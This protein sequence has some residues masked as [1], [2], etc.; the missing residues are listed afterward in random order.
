MKTGYIYTDEGLPTL[1][2]EF[3]WKIGQKVR[4]KHNKNWFFYEPFM[5][6]GCNMAIGTIVSIQRRF[7]DNRITAAVSYDEANFTIDFNFCELRKA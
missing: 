5:N 7:Y 2:K 3:E 4:C 1:D 6:D